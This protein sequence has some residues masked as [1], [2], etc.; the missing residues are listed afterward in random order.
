MTNS[1]RVGKARVATIVNW[2]MLF[3]AF[4][5]ITIGYVRLDNNQEAIKELAAKRA[6]DNC[7]VARTSL[8]PLHDIIV[9]TTKPADLTGLSGDRLQV[10]TDLNVQRA[11][12]RAELLKLIPVVSCPAT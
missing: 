5:A 7:E 10:V 12:A 11:T 6:Q 8:K 1:H 9:F 3:I 4:V 2:G